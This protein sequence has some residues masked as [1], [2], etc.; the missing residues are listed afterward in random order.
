MMSEQTMAAHYYT[1]DNL[2]AANS[3]GYLVKRCGILMTQIAEQ[4][5]ESEP[6]SFT[7]WIVLMQLTQ[8]VHLSPTELSTHLGHDM[9]ALTR[10]VDELQAKKLV[11]RE[12]S[13]QDRRAVQITATP[14]GRRLAQA[15]K[16]VVVELIN[17]LVAPY[18]KAET[19]LLV[20]LLQRMLAH[21]Q[22]FAGRV[23]GKA[24]NLDP[25]EV[26]ASGRRATGEAAAR[27]RRPARR[28]RESRS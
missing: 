9:G 10:I 11:V 2:E 25:P 20:S 23:T 8:H 14:E 28:R 3:V 1:L 15:T 18:S 22:D 27:S 16:A 21:M 24:S 26:R 7:H 6:I 12:R 17:E 13:E 5:F 4:R 19:E